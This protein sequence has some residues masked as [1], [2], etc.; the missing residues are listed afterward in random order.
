M[1]MS[2]TLADSVEYFERDLIA[3]FD[4]INY[5]EI[6][7]YSNVRSWGLDRIDQTCECQSEKL[8]TLLG[9]KIVVPACL[10]Q[11]ITCLPKPFLL[12]CAAL[13]LNGKFQI[14]TLSGEGSHVYV[15][16]TGLRATHADFRGRVGESTSIVGGYE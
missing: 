7:A 8:C 1:A 4:D 12:L 14:G 2:S 15:L 11:F 13:P 3:T 5:S 6:G 16:D 10:L 9:S